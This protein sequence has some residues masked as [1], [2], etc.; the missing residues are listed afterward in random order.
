MVLPHMPYPSASSL[1]KRTERPG[2]CPDLSR[3]SLNPQPLGACAGLR[4]I[5]IGDP[6]VLSAHAAGRR[7]GRATLLY[8]ASDVD[9]LTSVFKPPMMIFMLTTLTIDD[10]LAGL[11]KRR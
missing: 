10:D 4:P 9:A 11:L 8:H 7:S 1:A 2:H 6:T 3:H 5:S